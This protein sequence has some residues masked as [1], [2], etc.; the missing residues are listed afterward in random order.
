MNKINKNN[1][2]QRGGFILQNMK[3]NTIQVLLEYIL[4]KIWKW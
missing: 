1:W 3:S 2:N 4:A